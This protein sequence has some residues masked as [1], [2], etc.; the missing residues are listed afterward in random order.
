[1]SCKSKREEKTDGNEGGDADEEL[2]SNLKDVTADDL[3][4]TTDAIAVMAYMTTEMNIAAARAVMQMHQH[5]GNL[6]QAVQVQEEID[7]Q[8]K[9]DHGV[10]PY[11][12]P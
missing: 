7:R 2:F 6:L 4:P 5:H 11:D 12:L 3:I 8:V 1:M 9:I 10:R